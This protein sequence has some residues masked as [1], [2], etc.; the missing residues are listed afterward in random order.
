MPS[1]PSLSANH[2]HPRE[3]A[4]VG[5]CAH[6]NGSQGLF[7]VQRTVVR[8]AG[9][10]PS[11][12]RR[13]PAALGRCTVRLTCLG[14]RW[15]RDAAMCRRACVDDRPFS[16]LSDAEGW[17]PD[18]TMVR[19]GPTHYTSE[20]VQVCIKRRDLLERFVA[21]GGRQT[22]RLGW[23]HPSQ[24][25]RVDLLTARGIGVRSQCEC[26]ACRQGKDRPEPVGE[27]SD[28]L[29]PRYDRARAHPTTSH[30]QADSAG[31]RQR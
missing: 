15:G 29:Y 16:W 6:G 25:A 7:R 22:E 1:A 14:C 19:R 4:V 30:D 24:W 10:G 9:L 11:D 31:A 17:R 18:P 12:G 3:R 26:D 20:D 5:C 2:T 23:R 27:D 13:G 8:Q 28:V 21:S